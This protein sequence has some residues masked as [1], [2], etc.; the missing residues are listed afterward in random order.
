M[1]HANQVSLIARR[2]AQRAE[3][4][5][6]LWIQWKRRVIEVPRLLN[7][8]RQRKRRP[9][10]VLCNRNRASLPAAACTVRSLGA[11][12]HSR[13]WLPLTKSR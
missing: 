8:G 2:K 11:T 9:I 1:R 6:R 10:V 5:V 7:S 3:C 13:M 12:V 4:A